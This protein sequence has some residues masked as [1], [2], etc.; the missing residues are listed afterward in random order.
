MNYADNV[1]SIRCFRITL[2]H[3]LPD[4]DQILSRLFKT[5]Y[6][7]HYLRKHTHRF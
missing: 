3:K 7:E 6:F 1:Q 4:I 5:D 2:G